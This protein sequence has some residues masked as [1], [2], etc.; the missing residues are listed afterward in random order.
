MA[1]SSTDDTTYGFDSTSGFTYPS[2]STI[3]AELL[4]SYQ[5]NYGTSFSDDDTNAMWRDALIMAEREYKVWQMLAMMY[6]YQTYSGAEDVYLDDMFNRVGINR[7]NA[8]AAAGYAIIV[9]NNGIDTSDTLG[10]SAVFSDDSS[11]QFQLSESATFGDLVT[12]LY[13]LKSDLPSSSTSITITFESTGTSGATASVTSTVSSSITDSEAKT[14]F[15]KIQEA[16]EEVSDVSSD[17][18]V[19]YGTNSEGEVCLNI[20][21]S[22]DGDLEGVSD[23]ISM[24]MS[25]AIGLKASEFYVT[26]TETGYLTVVAGDIDSISPS[27]SS[28]DSITNLS[29]FSTGS[30]VESDAAYRTR[31]ISEI[32]A[33]GSGTKTSIIKAVLDVDNVTSCIIKD[34]PTLDDEDYADAMT[35][36]TIVQGGESADIAQAISDNKPV[37]AMTFGSTSYAITQED[38]SIETIYFTRATTVTLYIKIEYETVSGISFTTGEKEDIEDNISDVSDEYTVGGTVFLANIAAAV[39]DSLDTNRLSD[40]N[41]Y[42]RLSEDDD[43]LSSNYI[44]DYYEIP[45]IDTDNNIT[46]TYSGD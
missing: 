29:T 32:G 44:P 19:H 2:L 7:K 42:Y 23:P 21:Y 5:T 6:D 10:T 33:A 4:E 22:V 46:Y 17:D 38:D 14:F 34:N 1:T 25:T 26:C 3:K 27:N 18:T 20:G 36:N 40:L 13:I 37:N 30:D 31:Y 41:V 35:F 15:L 39:F 45:T 9:S 24:T 11:N 28:Y 16:F 8:S 43:W 12:G